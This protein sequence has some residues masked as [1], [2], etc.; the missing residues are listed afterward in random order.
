MADTTPN[1]GRRTLLKAIPAIALAGAAL[2]WG[3]LPRGLRAAVAG[4]FPTRTVERP[5]FRFDAARGEVV[6]SDGRREAYSLLL[7]GLTREPVRLSYARLRGLPQVRRTADFHCVEGWSV[8]DAPWGGVE[9][10]ELFARARILPG[11]THAVFHALG[12][13]EAVGGL[14]HYVESLPLADLLNP[15]LGCL[16]ALD[17]DGAPLSDERGAPARVVAPFD[18]AYKSIKF[19]TRVEFTDHPLPGW[20][21]R[22]NPIY[23]THAPVE[24]SRLRTPDPR[25]GDDSGR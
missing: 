4:R 6:F 9:F 1:A 24:P 17:L 7:D 8:R 20:W 12:R 2:L 25:G 13:T 10:R 14:T 23:P 22:A 21:T 5:T 15:A 3:W 19:V 11:A 16:L 18:L